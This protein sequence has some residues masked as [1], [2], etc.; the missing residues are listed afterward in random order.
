MNDLKVIYTP[1]GEKELRVLNDDIKKQIEESLVKKKY[2][3]G[4]SCVE[5]TAYDIENLRRK[6]N[7]KSAD[8]RETSF[9]V[10]MYIVGMIIILTVFIISTFLF[11][12]T[13]SLDHDLNNTL[14]LLFVMLLSSGLFNLSIYLRNRLSRT[15][16]AYI[17]TDEI[18]T[19][20]TA[21][22]DEYMFLHIDDEGNL[23][24]KSWENS[25]YNLS[26]LSIDEMKHTISKL[27]P[28]S[29]K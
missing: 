3:V 22:Q 17:T 7:I 4:D 27:N 23:K 18:D 16:R 14:Y 21:H 19:L 9:G 29:K 20:E 11:F 24:E 8:E 25:T 12:K 1:G 13:F 5:I 28:R 15:K 2:A 6:I 10:Y 26:N